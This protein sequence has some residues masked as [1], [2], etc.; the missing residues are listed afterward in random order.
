M[1]NRQHWTRAQEDWTKA[2]NG[3]QL[4]EQKW[5]ALTFCNV[6]DWTGPVWRGRKAKQFQGGP[7]GPVGI[8]LLMYKLNLP[9]LR[10]AFLRKS[11][12]VTGPLDRPIWGV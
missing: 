5:Y 9:Q 3:S 11:R 12:E 1:L 4:E 10:G 8:G 2:K 6:S 7:V